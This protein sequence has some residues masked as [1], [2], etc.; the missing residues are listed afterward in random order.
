VTERAV[1]DSQDVP[2][3]VGTTAHFYYLD[4]HQSMN[5]TLVPIVAEK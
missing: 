2:P 4:V 3:L 1:A 5:L